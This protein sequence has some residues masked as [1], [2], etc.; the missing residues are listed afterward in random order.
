MELEIGGKTFSIRKLNA[1]DQCDLSRRVAPL[2]PVIIPAMQSLFD[3][4]ASGAERT[5]VDLTASVVVRLQPLFEM[6]GA[7]N[8]DDYFALI[9]LALKSVQI[10]TEDRVFHDLIKEGELMYD[11]LGYEVLHILCIR[12]CVENL[13]PTLPLAEFMKVFSGTSPENR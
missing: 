5:T 11:N 2:L 9:K 8:R 1:F 10:R 12:S 4:A 3:E 7:M 13:R 6:L